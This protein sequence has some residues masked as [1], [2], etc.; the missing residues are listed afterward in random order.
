MLFELGEREHVLLLLLHH[1]AGDGWSLAPLTRDLATAY[2]ARREGRAPAFTPLP[3]SYADY[4]LW[5]RDLLGDADDPASPHAAQLAHWRDAL[6]GAPAQL[7]LPTDHARPAVASHRGATVEFRLDAALHDRL[8]AL[9]TACDS[10]LFMVLQAAFAAVL[11]R[12]GAGTDIPVGSPVA[13]RTDDALDQ[14][15]GF[16]V[17]T[18][19]L[20]TDTSG[21]PAFRDLVRRVREVD[22]AAYTHQDLPFEKLVEE[23][24]PERTL[25]RNPLFQVVLALQSMPAPTRPC[26]AWTSPWSRC[27]WASPSSTSVSPSSRSTPP[28]ASGPGSAATGS[29]APSCSSAA[30]WRPSANVWNASCAPSPRTPGGPSDRSTCSARPNAT[31]CWSTSTPPRRGRSARPRCPP[32]SRSRPPA[33]PTPSRWSWARGRSRTRN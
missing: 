32:C 28:T 6:S 7:D 26:R 1:I 19:V 31:G 4:T 25:A 21:D 18:L 5:Q 29:T 11:T 22:L 9:A 2:A 27:G 15:V 23:L 12:H 20:R 8:A 14:L 13:G 10:S 33:P 30:P 3:V 17:N 24:N 16:F